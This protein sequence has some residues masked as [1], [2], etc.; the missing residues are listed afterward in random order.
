MKRKVFG[1]V[2]PILENYKLK[3]S[4]VLGFKYAN[5]LGKYLGTYGD[6]DKQKS[7]LYFELFEKIDK[8]L[9]AWRA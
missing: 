6:M 5:K 9:Q 1:P 2:F 3:L 7:H 4:N 8:N